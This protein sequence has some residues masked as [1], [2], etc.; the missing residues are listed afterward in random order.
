MDLIEAP[1]PPSIPEPLLLP[2]LPPTTV[3]V[4]LVTPD[5]TV[6]VPDSFALY[7]IV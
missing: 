1:K 7:V 5:G 2:P 4:A 3:K 6:Q